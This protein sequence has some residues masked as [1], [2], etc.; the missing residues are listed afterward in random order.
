[1]SRTDCP[2]SPHGFLPFAY[3]NSG[4]NILSGPGLF[5]VNTTLMKYW[6]VS[7]RKRVQFRYEVFNIT[8]H[9]NFQLPNIDFDEVNAGIISGVRQGGSGG[10]REMQFALKFEF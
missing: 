6:N 7:E 10:S 9:P 4:R 1:V 2:A 5:Y 3:G 8:N